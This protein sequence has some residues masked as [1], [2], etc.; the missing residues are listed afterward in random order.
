MTMGRLIPIYF[1]LI[2]LFSGLSSLPLALSDV[3]TS[4]GLGKISG[5]F[6]QY[7]SW[8][9]QMDSKKWEPE[10]DAMQ[11]AGIDTLVIQ[12]VKSDQIRFYPVNIPGNDPTEIIL[13]YADRK[14]MKVYVGL[15]NDK[16]W[17]SNWGDEDYLQKAAQKTV[18]LGKS[19]LKRYGRHRSFQGWYIPYE[20]SDADFDEDETKNAKHFLKKLSLGLKK[21]SHKKYPIG[22]STFFSGKIPPAAVQ[23]IYSE[24]LE[25]SGVNILMVQDG[26]GVHNW[27][28]QIAE[29]VVP[30]MNAFRLAAQKNGIH[31]WSVVES[32]ADT[33]NAAEKVTPGGNSE[34]APTDILRLKEQL[35]IHAPYPHEKILTFDFFHYM[36]PYRGVAQKLL[37]DNYLSNFRT[38]G[39]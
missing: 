39:R 34:R 32:F 20:M 27:N 30:Y 33:K 4:P 21:L 14:H 13:N 2:A 12:W 23:K 15:Q 3:P 38:S 6:I 37:Y 22:L 8:M 16:N 24:I 5:T 36:S 25:G 19:V 31:V 17:W 9:M 11:A 29:K 7:Q 10:L 1:Y 35:Q 18:V 28:N 26:V